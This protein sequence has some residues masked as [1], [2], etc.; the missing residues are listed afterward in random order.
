MSVCT[1]ICIYVFILGRVL[2]FNPGPHAASSE[3]INKKEN[4][5]RL[6]QN[7]ISGI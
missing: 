5:S 6:P 7:I 1:Y 3:K 2:R 4:Y